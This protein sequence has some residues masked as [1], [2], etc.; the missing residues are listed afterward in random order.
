MSQHLIVESLLPVNTTLLF[1]LNE[2]VATEELWPRNVR[3]SWWVS[4]S[5]SRTVYRA[6][7][8]TKNSTGS[9]PPK[10][11]EKSNCETVVSMLS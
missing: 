10:R 11:A 5:Y 6:T 7:Q 2:M 8:N 4:T 3:T 1:G 9:H